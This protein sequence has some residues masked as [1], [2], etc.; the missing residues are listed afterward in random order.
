MKTQTY[1]T[2]GFPCYHPVLVLYCC[3][4]GK[5]SP[6]CVYKDHRFNGSQEDFK[7][8]NPPYDVDGKIT[9]IKGDVRGDYVYGVKN[10]EGKFE[11]EVR[12]DEGKGDRK[13]MEDNDRK[14]L[15]DL[16]DKGTLKEAEPDVWRLREIDK[17]QRV[18]IGEWWSQK[19][20]M[21]N[22]S[23]ILARSE[24]DYKQFSDR[25]AEE[26]RLQAE[27]VRLQRELPSLFTKTRALML[28]CQDRVRLSHMT[29]GDRLQIEEV[30][31]H[32]KDYQVSIFHEKTEMEKEV[33]FFTQW[34]P[35]L[36][37]LDQIVMQRIK[38]K[39]IR[40]EKEDA[41]NKRKEQEQMKQEEIDKRFDTFV[42]GRQSEREC[43]KLQ[44]ELQ[45]LYQEVIQL[46]KTIRSNDLTHCDEKDQQIVLGVE[47]H[48]NQCR[49]GQ[50]Q[51]ED[52]I[53]EA[54]TQ[55]NLDK[56]QLEK[57]EQTLLKATRSHGQETLRPLLTFNSIQQ[58]VKG[59]VTDDV[60]SVVIDADQLMD[61][62]SAQI[63]KEVT[64]LQ[65]KSLDQL[66]T[67]MA[68]TQTLLARQNRENEEQRIAI[69]NNREEH[70]SRIQE[71]EQQLTLARVY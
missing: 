49:D 11:Y 50:M 64:Q 8:N 66:Q 47:R 63:Q 61:R 32:I 28:K 29:N 40:K 51:T 7:K 56:S 17:A 69:Q 5:N 25:Q 67:D 41:E 52:R 70:E 54:I 12:Y 58:A 21:P 6:R 68:R 22:I 48:L 18:D 46:D 42:A 45:V 39:K 20:A 1:G 4:D 59:Q 24:Q 38:E 57:L 62:V 14:Y 34:I 23:D 19:L 15:K 3:W 2:R 43:A 10:A 30:S 33:A 53:K 26:A 37:E 35:Y 65:V 13:W 36:Q 60:T 27:E 9:W 55:L 31:T 16:L 44:S 71:L